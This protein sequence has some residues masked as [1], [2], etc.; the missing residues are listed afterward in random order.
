MSHVPENESWHKEVKTG[1]LQEEIG[2]LQPGATLVLRKR[3]SSRPYS[4]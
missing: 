3:N 1:P 2:K 4:H